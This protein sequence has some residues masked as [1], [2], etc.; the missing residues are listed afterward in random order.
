MNGLLKDAFTVLF[1]RG[2]I[3]LAQL[4]SFV[5]LARYLSPTDFGWFGLV[6]T[7]MALA[8]TIGSLG[9]RQ[10]TAFQI[11]RGQ[12]SAGEGVGTIL[13][14][15]LPL[16]TIASVVV[17]I[18]Y[19]W[20]LPGVSSSA[21][22]AAMFVGISCTMLIMMLQGVLL[23]RSEI[24][25]FSTT[26]TLP[27]V[28]L[29]VL[30]L[31]LAVTGFASAITAVWAQAIS[32]LLIVPVAILLSRSGTDGLGFRIDRIPSLV[33]YGI[34]FAINL[35][36]ITLCARISMF[37][38]ERIDSASSA[39]VFFAAIRVNDIFLEAASALGLV[40]FSRSVQE[41]DTSR[42]VQKTARVACWMIW[43]FAAAAIV[44]AASAPFLVRIVL[45]N[46]YESA[47]T[48]LTVLAI[49][50]P[51]AAAN[52]VIYPAIAGQG[53]PWF[54]TVVIFISLAVNTSLAALLVP[55]IGIL[56]GAA[57]LV[58]GQYAMLAGYIITCNRSFGVT[59]RSFLLP[60]SRDASAIIATVSKR[61]PNIKNRR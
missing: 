35:F 23:G 28:V 50:L 21:T 31:A 54:G 53:R 45:G 49:G 29:A 24:R 47:G 52:K 9:L 18:A 3:R 55:K 34:A 39:G 8:A 57:A 16:A 58:A 56:G 61:L 32:F 42:V 7:A 60:S 17:T 51:A 43:S 19:D 10:S 14:S 41:A 40:V 22:A 11:G 30:S 36:L 37:V 44:T 38:I 1:A 25:S 26:E 6:T 59:I 20:N 48:A 15:W 46:A 33:A 12:I 4:G 27:R 13:A 5:I 2:F